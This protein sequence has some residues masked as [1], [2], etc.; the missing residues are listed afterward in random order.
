M[1]DLMDLEKVRD[2]NRIFT[3]INRIKTQLVELPALTARYA[4]AVNALYEISID[5]SQG[6]EELSSRALELGN[7]IHA[8]QGAY[9]EIE[10]LELQ[11]ERYGIIRYDQRQAA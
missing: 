1:V 10:K 7:A 3:E 5:D 9:K 6:G 11:L 4:D 8:A 2:I